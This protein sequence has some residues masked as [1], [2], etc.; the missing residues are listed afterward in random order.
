MQNARFQ[1]QSNQILF[2]KA[3]IG[4][5]GVSLTYPRSQVVEYSKIYSIAPVTYIT[6]P[7]GLKSPATLILEPFTVPLWFSILF[8]LISVIIYQKFIVYK[9]IKN[10]NSDIT[11]P[12]I[13]ALLRQGKFIK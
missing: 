3:D 8:A 7:N 4:V 12:L 10:K 11:W 9:V 5:G 2:Q 13:S 6:P 1:K